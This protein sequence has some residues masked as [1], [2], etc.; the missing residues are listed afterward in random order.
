M[1]SIEQGLHG[2]RGAM[3]LYPA[4]YNAKKSFSAE[5]SGSSRWLPVKIMWDYDWDELTFDDFI[6]GKF[7]VLDF[8]LAMVKSTSNDKVVLVSNYTQTLD[9]FQRLCAIRGYQYVRLDGSMSIKKRSKVVDNFNDPTVCR[10]NWSS[11]E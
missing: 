4:G 5:L 8:I 7:K 10:S 1:E 6:S 11:L 2:L 9:L 3:E